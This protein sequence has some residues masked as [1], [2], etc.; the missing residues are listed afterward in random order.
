M[1]Y[2]NYCSCSSRR[3]G[4][5]QGGGADART[6]VALSLFLAAWVG[7]AAPARAQYNAP[8]NQYDLQRGQGGGYDLPA[9]QDTAQPQDIPPAAPGHPL[10][11]RPGMS[12]MQGELIPARTVALQG[13]GWSCLRPGW[14]HPLAL[15]RLMVT[16]APPP[17]PSTSFRSRSW[18]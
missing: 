7:F 5:P 14:V 13:T 16:P 4:P 12:L 6:F 9:P 17:G 11:D 15:A 8:G 10:P 3:M 2:E 18:A 1:F